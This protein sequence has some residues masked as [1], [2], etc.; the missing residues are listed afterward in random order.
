M[1]DCEIYER[2]VKRLIHNGIYDPYAAIVQLEKEID[3]YRE[4][5]VRLE[6]KL[7]GSNTEEPIIIRCKDCKWVS[8]E[9]SEG[10]ENVYVCNRT[11]WSRFR[12]GNMPD[13]FCSLGERKNNG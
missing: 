1:D 3:Y 9:P 8:Y 13:D 10:Y 12:G 6:E 5:I 2:C 11:P 4:K 7:K